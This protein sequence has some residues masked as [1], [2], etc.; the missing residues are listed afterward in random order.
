MM[1]SFMQVISASSFWESASKKDLESIDYKKNMNDGPQSYWFQKV[2]FFNPVYL[3][4]PI[5]P[6]VHITPE[7]LRHLKI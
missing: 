4:D 1:S 3:E 5:P 6:K 2:F 7:S